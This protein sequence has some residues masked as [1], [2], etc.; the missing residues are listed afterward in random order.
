MIRNVIEYLQNSVKKYP[1]KI[2]LIGDGE[3]ITFREL[4]EEAEKIASEI[5]AQCGNIKN[6]PIAVYMEKNIHCI[7]AFLGIVYSGNFYSPI[8]VKSPISRVQYIM[9]TL[10]PLAIIDNGKWIE[11]MGNS[12]RIISFSDALKKQVNPNFVRNYKNI[13][14]TDPL[15]VLFTSGSTGR[16][17]GVV[18]SH[19]G[20]I[21]YVE[22]L[23]NKFAFDEDTVFGNQAPF[24]FDNSILDIY[25]TLRNAATMVI[26]PEK[27]FMFP[28]MLLEYINQNDI[29]TIFWVPS[30]LISVA[31][32]GILSEIL[33]PKLKRVLFCG[34]VMPNKQLNMW[35]KEYPEIFYAN[36]YGPTEI[37]DVCTYYIVD[38]SFDD[39]ESLPIGYACENTD[40]L[41][42]NK[43]NEE[44]GPD[45]LGELCVRGTCLSMGYYGDYEKTDSVFV[46]NPLNSKFHE[47]I[48]RTG[49]L[50][51]YNERGELIYVCRKDF[52]IKHQGHRIELG[53]IE[54]A[55]GSLD[56]IEQNCAI[57][58]NNKKR[59]ILICKTSE[60]VDKKEIY[61]NLKQKLPQYMLPAQIEVVNEMPLNLNG[62][63]D[64][65]KLK[66]ELMR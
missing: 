11:N 66:D 7:A 10:E 36:L 51:K 59:I 38:R 39:D 35:R 50:V 42:L 60:K 28:K 64:R 8:D 31:N 34:E 18:I 65:A 47:I 14:D 58:D 62:K 55:A 43:N 9:E 33:M 32:S 49:D 21:D 4:N 24:Y 37:T 15:Y 20:V 45:E 63:I 57:Y 29:N 25:S 2:A 19:K 48:Y 61:Q 41:V 12:Q 13:L 23:F 6:K 53:E 46:Q 30:A 3:Q 26:I 22:W 54:M 16:P 44:V 5:I 40:I 52:Q 56:G 27:L 1:D 17:K